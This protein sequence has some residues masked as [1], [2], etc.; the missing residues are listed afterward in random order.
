MRLRAVTFAGLL[1]TLALSCS[2]PGPAPVPLDLLGKGSCARAEQLAARVPAWHEELLVERAH[3]VVEEPR[4]R[5]VH[6]PDDQVLPGSFADNARAPLREL[7][8]AGVPGSPDEAQLEALRRLEREETPLSA[9]PDPWLRLHQQSAGAVRAVLLA[10][11]SREGRIPG[12]SIYE[13]FTDPEEEFSYTVLQPAI[14]LAGFQVLAERAAGRTGE[15]LALCADGLMLGTDHARSSLLGSMVATSVLT[16]LVPV[17]SR[18]VLEATPAER[19]RFLE[20][21]LVVRSGWPTFSQ[22]LEKERVFLQLGAFGR[23]LSAQTVARLPAEAHGLLGQLR[24]AEDSLEGLRI[25]AF[26]GYAH[27]KFLIH[28]GELIEA[29]R[30]PMPE[31]RERMDRSGDTT[32]LASFLL[33][34]GEQPMSSWS[35][36][37]ARAR[38][39]EALFDGLLGMAAAA[40]FRDQTGQW[41]RSWEFLPAPLSVPRC[42]NTSQPIELEADEWGARL[43]VPAVEGVEDEPIL[44]GFPTLPAPRE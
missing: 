22:T 39:A 43:T 36:F 15:A 31:A 12:V 3:C 26:G 34:G 27:R 40:E 28:Y 42:P 14:R 7:M 30:L 2:E 1:A 24:F 4:L 19:G 29:S 8:E 13:I 18:A 41:P 35:L 9:L 5:Q 17:C 38:K 6:V 25:V 44:L 33:S 16:R 21:G 37:L 32:R 23:R 11:R 10:S 20:Q